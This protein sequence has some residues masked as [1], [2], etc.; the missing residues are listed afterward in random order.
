MKNN[1]NITKIENIANDKKSI[2]YIDNYYINNN[3]LYLKYYIDKYMGKCIKRIFFIDEKLFI[4]KEINKN[5]TAWI[6]PTI[7]DVI[8]KNFHKKSFQQLVIKNIINEK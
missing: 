2:Q 6:E 8:S 7:L 3:I 1:L 5:R 4:S